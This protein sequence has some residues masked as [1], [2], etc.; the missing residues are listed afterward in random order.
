MLDTPSKKDEDFITR[1]KINDLI[2]EERSAISDSKVTIKRT[3]ISPEENKKGSCREFI[4]YSN[5]TYSKELSSI[6]I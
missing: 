3:S 6:Y 4:S 5:H 2:C 1:E